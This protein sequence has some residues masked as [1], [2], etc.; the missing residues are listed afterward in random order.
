ME[1]QGRADAPDHSQLCLH[2]AAVS[3]Y[4]SWNSQAT[5]F[6]KAKNLT[7]SSDVSLT[8]AMAQSAEMMRSRNAETEEQIRQLYAMGGDH[9]SFAQALMLALDLEQA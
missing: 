4:C 5:L 3:I 1:E 7:E 6:E 2:M 8:D 9:K